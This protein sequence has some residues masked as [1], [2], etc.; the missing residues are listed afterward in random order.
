[1]NGV[2]GDGHGVRLRDVTPEDLVLIERWV[3]ADHVRRF[4]GE[5]DENIRLFRRPPAGMCCALIAVDGRK[6][7]LV[8]WQHPSRQELDEV[9]L[10]EIP[11]TVIDIDIMIGEEDAV[12]RGIGPAA[13]DLVAEAA[14]ADPLVPFVMAGISVD[15]GASRRAFEKAGFRMEREFDDVPGGRCTLMIRRRG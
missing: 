9:G 2:R 12:G 15:N 11:E 13:V 8:V 1:M 14:L 3:R 5:P 10:K 4:W 7:G 6:V